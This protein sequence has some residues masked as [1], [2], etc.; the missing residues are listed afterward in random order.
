M[1][2]SCFINYRDDGCVRGV[3]AA[4]VLHG[5]LK[6]K[7]CGLLPVDVN[8]LCW[9]L[10]QTEI[11]FKLLWLIDCFAVLTLLFSQRNQGIC[12]IC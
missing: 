10:E 5:R 4:P 8:V 1:V 3:C 12:G 9:L 11:V 2:Q 7:V 6:L